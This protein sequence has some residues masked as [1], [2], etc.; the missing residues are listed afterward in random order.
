MRRL[1]RENVGASTS[2][3]PMASTACYRDSFMLQFFKKTPLL[4]CSPANFLVYDPKSFFYFSVFRRPGREDC[5]ECFELYLHFP[6]FFMAWCLIKRRDFNFTLT[7]LQVSSPW[8]QKLRLSSVRTRTS[9]VSVGSR[10]ADPYA[11][12]GPQDVQS[13]HCAGHKW[14]LVRANVAQVPYGCQVLKILPD[15]QGKVPV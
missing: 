12:T 7:P 5:E 10:W 2:H 1:S 3:N 14:P 15:T 8:L 9:K 13:V 11:T 6:C 4:A